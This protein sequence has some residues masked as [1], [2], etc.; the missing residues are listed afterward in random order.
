[1]IKSWISRDL[2]LI[3]YLQD[4][5]TNLHH[6]MEKG[7]LASL[8]LFVS[9]CH[10]RFFGGFAGF[11]RLLSSRVVCVVVYGLAR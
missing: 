11:A 3:E 4:L 10:R 1:M 2:I 8:Y 9:A 7:Q 5:D 6:D